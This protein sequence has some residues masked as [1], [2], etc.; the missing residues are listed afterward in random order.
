MPPLRLPRAVRKR[1]PRPIRSLGWRTL[2]RLR[3]PA[4]GLLMHYEGPATLPMPVAPEGHILRTWQPGD[5][6]SWITLL[7]DS[8]TFG[9]WDAERLEVEMAT[10]VREAQFFV[11]Q[12]EALVAA[13]GIHARKLDGRDAFEV[14][15][16]VRHPRHSGRGL[17][18]ITVQAA[19]SI[20]QEVE[21][22]RRVFLYTD[23][24]RLTAIQMYLDLGFVPDLQKH[25]R[26]AERWDRVRAELA[27]RE[28]AAP[29]G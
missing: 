10:L 9:A 27:R 13:T 17:G 26:Y 14:G 16:V 3:N 2:Q 6:E 22:H 4:P 19:L 28:A 21:P 20:A 11:V 18:R 15:W 25:P 24:Y 5:D 12:G 8:Q 1:I 7:N 29:A 23:D